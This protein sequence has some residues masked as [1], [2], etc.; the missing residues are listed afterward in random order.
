LCPRRIAFLALACGLAGGN[1]VCACGFEAWAGSWWPETSAEL[2][3]GVVLA[4]DRRDPALSRSKLR[5]LHGKVYGLCF[6]ALPLANPYA[7]S[8]ARSA[9]FQRLRAL[10]FDPSWWRL[11][12]TS[13]ARQCEV[14][15]IGRELG[16]SRQHASSFSRSIASWRYQERKSSTRPCFLQEIEYPFSQ[17]T[18]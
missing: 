4:A 18:T 2:V 7:R 5:S 15:R 12:V 17:D 10:H 9:Q 11:S 14:S 13:V 16:S 8:E 6:W 3:P 1:Q